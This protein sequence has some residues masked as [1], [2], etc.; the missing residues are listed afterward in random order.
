MEMFAV[1]R[2]HRHVRRKDKDGA[3]VSRISITI[4]TNY[5]PEVGHALVDLT[6]VPALIVSMK[7][8]QTEM[9]LD[10][11]PARGDQD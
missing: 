10:G 11:K 2:S 8:L 9:D 5:V 3:D 6:C 1:L 7:P 4:E